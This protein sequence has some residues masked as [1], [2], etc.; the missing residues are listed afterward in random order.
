MGKKA[1]GSLIGYLILFVALIWL[2]GKIG[3][4]L[5]LGIV[6]L[7]VAGWVFVTFAKKDR[8]KKESQAESAIDISGMPHDE[9]GPIFDPP[10]IASSFYGQLMKIDPDKSVRLRSQ[11]IMRESLQIAL[12]SKKPDM[13]EHHMAAAEKIFGELQTEHSV[14]PEEWEPIRERFLKEKN[15]YHTAKYINQAKGLLEHGGKL[16]TEKSKQKYKDMAS[17]VIEEGLADSL[18]D[19]KRLRDFAD[20]L[21]DYLKS[22]PQKKASPESRNTKGSKETKSKADPIPMLKKQ[23]DGIGH[24]EFPFNHKTYSPSSRVPCTDFTPFIVDR[25]REQD[26]ESIKTLMREIISGNPGLGTGPGWIDAE[27]ES[28]MKAPLERYLSFDE[29]IALFELKAMWIICSKSGGKRKFWISEKDKYTLLFSRALC[30]YHFTIQP[31]VGKLIQPANDAI[32][33]LAEDNDYWKE[34]PK[35]D[36]TTLQIPSLPESQCREKILSLSLGARLHLFQAV[37]YGKGAGSLPKSTDY[38][39]R[40][41]GLFVPETTREIL[42]S[43]LMI[44]SDKAIDLETAFSR[45]GLLAVCEENEADF[46]KSWNKGKLLAALEDQCP[47]FIRTS[48]KD[49]AIVTVN[50]DFKEDLDEICSYSERLTAFYKLLC[51]A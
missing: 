40:N 27:V 17:G 29:E 48:L 36:S 30:A 21:E 14:P 47:D 13:A 24:P 51:F 22:V 39:T 1:G 42:D 18:A 4:G 35:F 16:K 5:V 28:V 37:S 8:V 7:L 32:E 23:I 31:A 34:Y 3:W 41:F 33:K 38:A 45:K 19:K 49:M 15:T 2:L 44:P 12:S 50:P 9:F 25:L 46:R 10:Q 6:S 26:Q 11:Q 20:H 43:T